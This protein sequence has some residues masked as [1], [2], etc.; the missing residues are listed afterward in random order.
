LRA[1]GTK[2]R[3]RAASAALSAR[4]IARVSLDPRSD[5][6]IVACFDGHSF[7]VGK[8]S[9]PTAS[10]AQDL[11]TGLP[12]DTLAS[13]DE[14]IDKEVDRLVRRLARHGLLEYGFGYS[15]DDGDDVVIE[16]QLADY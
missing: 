13:Q 15:R 9:P 11:R 10:R 4:L 5:G 2:K 6:T 8:F 1:S 7:G 14:P 16:P 3:R 12:L